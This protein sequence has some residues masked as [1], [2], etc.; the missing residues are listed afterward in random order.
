M[1]LSS[2]GAVSI[3]M[4]AK[5]GDGS[6]GSGKLAE[7][8]FLVGASVSSG[9]LTT[10]RL[11]EVAAVDPTGAEV[12]LEARP[13]TIGIFKL[14]G[15]TARTCDINADGRIGLEDVIVFL[16]LAG[17]NQAYPGFDRDADGRYSASDALDLLLDIRQRNCPDSAAGLSGAN[18]GFQ[19]EGIRKQPLLKQK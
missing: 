19:G 10:V 9:T 16:L 4:S 3:G 14:S 13:R 11:S 18:S 6:S 12:T 7:V 5:T 17:I 2:P 8:L 15:F 1:P